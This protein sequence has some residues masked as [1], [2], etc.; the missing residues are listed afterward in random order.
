MR[1]RPRKIGTIAND[2]AESLQWRSEQIFLG[3]AMVPNDQSGFRL[4]PDIYKPREGASGNLIPVLVRLT[5]TENIVLL[6]PQELSA[7]KSPL[8][9]PDCVEF[10]PVQGKGKIRLP[11]ALASAA[12]IR[13]RELLVIGLY[14]YC[15]VAASYLPGTIRK[16]LPEIQRIAM[17]F[18]EKEA[19][20]EA[21]ADPAQKS[22]I[23]N[24]AER[25]KTLIR[26][27][28]PGLLEGGFEL[29]V[30]V[31]GQGERLDGITINCARREAPAGA[32]N[33]T[34]NRET[35]AAMIAADFAPAPAK[36][37]ADEASTG[38]TAEMIAADFAPAEAPPA[39]L[40]PP[41]AEEPSGTPQGQ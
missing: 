30:A 2:A 19:P 22:V 11:D 17:R 31:R 38:T 40:P 37:P 13:N 8:A 7:R 41:A 28:F 33:D 1:E 15:V 32:P 24:A 6:F 14:Q 34:Q 5:D 4:P 25:I 16:R 39:S 3:E 21:L 29:M 27:T 26:E 18:L 9:E 10:P 35:A 36:R 12:G 20:P 23:V